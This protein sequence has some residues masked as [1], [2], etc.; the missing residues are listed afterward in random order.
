MSFYLRCARTFH[1]DPK[2]NVNASGL[3]VRETCD[4]DMWW[5]PGVIPA[6]HT[7]GGICDKW[8][9]LSDAVKDMYRE[10]PNCVEPVC[11][12]GQNEGDK[13]SGN[14][15]YR[16]NGESDA[17]RENRNCPAGL[18]WDKALRHAGHAE[19]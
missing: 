13:C 2:E 9:N 14:H 11:E 18:V 12:W 6:G 3:W 10:D 1:D 8:I 15:W 17:D 7:E 4:D 5:N 19:M 16:E